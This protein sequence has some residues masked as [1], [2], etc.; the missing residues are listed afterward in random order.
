MQSDDLPE[1]DGNTLSYYAY[2]LLRDLH[3]KSKLLKPLTDDK[4]YVERNFINNKELWKA[5]GE[6]VQRNLAEVSNLEAF[7]KFYHTHVHMWTIS[8]RSGEYESLSIRPTIKGAWF[9][10]SYQETA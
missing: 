8:W 3:F 9:A 1:F 10:F 5:A 4:D 6:L 7:V 2:K